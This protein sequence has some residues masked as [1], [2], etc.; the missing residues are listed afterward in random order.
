MEA[1]VER[2]EA[3]V[4]ASA[5]SRVDLT[6]VTG[7]AAIGVVVEVARAAGSGASWFALAAVLCTVEVPA[8][9]EAPVGTSGYFAFKSA[10][11]GVDP[12]APVECSA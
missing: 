2:A 12:V 4:V 6:G 5:G 1:G 7:V 3:G 10:V 11:A 8:G 9:R